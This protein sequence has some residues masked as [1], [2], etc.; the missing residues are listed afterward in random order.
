MYELGVNGCDFV[1]AADPAFDADLALEGLG[2]SE[3]VIDVGAERVKR[4]FAVAIF[5]G[6]GDFSA[7]ETTGA[8][9]AD[10]FGTSHVHGSLDGFLHGIDIRIAARRCFQQRAARRV[11]DS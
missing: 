5:F 1:L 7:A 8:T 10:T 4:N 6:A 9:D 11:R 2:F 3:A